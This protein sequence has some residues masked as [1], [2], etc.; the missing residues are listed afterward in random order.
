MEY[1]AQQLYWRAEPSTAEAQPYERWFPL[2]YDAGIG[3]TRFIIM[4]SS[5]RL[6]YDIGRNGI[7]SFGSRQLGALQKILNSWPPDAK[8]LVLLLHH[9]IARSNRESLCEGCLKSWKAFTDSALF[10]YM[11]LRGD[12][13]ETRL[14]IGAL[15]TFAERRPNVEV[16]ILCG[17][18][19]RRYLGRLSSR[20]EVI[21]APAPHELPGAWLLFDDANSLTIKAHYLKLDVSQAIGAQ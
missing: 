8:R 7:G 3:G 12:T 19:H 4:N 11:F 1:C 18:R 5:N 20:F 16:T 14:L 17:H 9:P 10:N 6:G 15:S 13:A 2:V 21:E